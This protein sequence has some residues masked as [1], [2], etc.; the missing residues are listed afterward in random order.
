MADPIEYNI[1]RSFW[2]LARSTNNITVFYI[3]LQSIRRRYK[4]DINTEN[5]P[6]HLRNSS[7]FWNDNAMPIIDQ[8]HRVVQYCQ[9]CVCTSIVANN[10]RFFG[11]C[12]A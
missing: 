9:C 6:F 7:Y 12:A 3:G 8:M 1:F 4:Y 2:Q 5:I 11:L 10:P